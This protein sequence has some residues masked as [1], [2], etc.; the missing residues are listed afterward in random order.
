MRLVSND[1]VVI[2][3]I[4]EAA[5]FLER[6]LGWFNPCTRGRAGVLL[7]PCR[8]IHTLFMKE[9][10]DVVFLTRERTVCHVITALG[11]NRHASA[12]D[13]HYVLELGAGR[14]VKLNIREGQVFEFEY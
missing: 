14:V 3:N 9:P 10:I 1:G 11:R 4:G 2:D 8:A 13:A 5:S 7:H 6:L 12:P